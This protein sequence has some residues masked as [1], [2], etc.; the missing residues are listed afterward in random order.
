MLRCLLLQMHVKVRAH[1]LVLPMIHCSAIVTGMF[2]PTRAAGLSSALHSACHVHCSSRH[3]HSHRGPPPHCRDAS[4]EGRHRHLHGEWVLLLLTHAPVEHVP[5]A[6]SVTS[7]SRAWRRLHSSCLIFL[8]VIWLC[9][10]LSFLLN[11]SPPA[12]L[13]LSEKP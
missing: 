1:R 3:H 4:S 13:L 12:I 10:M 8:P 9:G 5:R 7:R 2:P 11:F 6:D